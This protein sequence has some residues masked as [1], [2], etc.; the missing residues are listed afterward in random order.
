MFEVVHFLRIFE[1]DC[2]TLGPVT[3]TIYSD[4]PGNSM[5]VR[6]VRTVDTSAYGRRTV[7]FR[8][9]GNTKGKLF[10][11]EIKALSTLRLFGARVFAKAIGTSASGDWA[12]F[13]LP[14][15]ETPEEWTAIKLPIDETPE[16]LSAIKLPIVDTP[17]DWSAI[18][19]PIDETPEHWTAVKAPIEETPDERP[20]KEFPVTL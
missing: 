7:R 11:F 8:L 3:L 4:L 2:S 1:C 5:A 14:V 9:S 13:P 16:E 18:K 20:W 17:E 6:E 19:L 12:W 15:V 10:R